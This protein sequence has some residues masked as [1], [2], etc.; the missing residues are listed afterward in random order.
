M[1]RASAIKNIDELVERLGGPALA[2]RILGTEPHQIQNWR[3]HGYIPAR[4][5]R[6]HHKLLDDLAVKV[7]DDVWGFLP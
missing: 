4:F 2:A 3:K 5:Y 7:K 6:A 1:S